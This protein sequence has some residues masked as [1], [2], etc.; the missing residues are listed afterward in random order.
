[1]SEPREVQAYSDITNIRPEGEV[2][3][4]PNVSRAEMLNHPTAGWAQ[5][6]TFAERTEAIRRDRMLTNPL[7]TPERPPMDPERPVLADEPV[8]APEPPVEP[9]PAPQ[10]AVEPVQEA[11]NGPVPGADSAEIT[12]EWADTAPETAQG[13]LEETKNIEE[14]RS[15]YTVIDDIKAGLLG[16]AN[17]IAEAGQGRELRAELD[18]QG[19][20]RI[21]EA[22]LDQLLSI[23]GTIREFEA[24][25]QS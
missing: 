18:A 9:V 19:L 10:E 7:P 1:M 2:D 12:L 8:P 5:E 14:D 6:M 11:E 13:D 22:T 15:P 4:R 25:L 21:G 24:K 23:E 16:R 3:F 20:P 17:A